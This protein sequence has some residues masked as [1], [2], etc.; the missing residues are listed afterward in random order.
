MFI[1][2]FIVQVNDA[3]EKG[4]IDALKRLQDE[5]IDVGNGNLNNLCVYAIEAVRASEHTVFQNTGKYE[6][7]LRLAGQFA[8]AAVGLQD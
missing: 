6:V 1:N 4:D 5:A 8:D 2:S 3:T 7:N